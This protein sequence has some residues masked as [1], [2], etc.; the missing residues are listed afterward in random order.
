[1][2]TTA[3]PP[4]PQ[5]AIIEL[6]GHIRYGGTITTDTQ[7]GTSMLRVEVPQE[8]GSFVSQLINPA[9]IYRVTFSD[10]ALARAAAILGNPKP[11]SMWE[12]K[13]L[14]PAA[15]IACQHQDDSEMADIRADD[16]DDDGQDE[17]HRY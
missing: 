10:E 2:Q 4:A 13:H 7:L 3:T 17:T 11:I 9:S 15:A 12:V 16:D 5:W 14:I 1:M 6:L 8:D